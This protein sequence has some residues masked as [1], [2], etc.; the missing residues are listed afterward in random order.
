VLQSKAAECGSHLIFVDQPYEGKISLAG[1]HQKWN[2]AV[3]VSATEASAFHVGPDSIADGLRGCRLA[4]P[5]ST[6]HR[7][8][9]VDGAHNPHAA[10][11]LV[12]TWRQQFGNEKAP[13]IF[14][15]LD[16]KDYAEMLKRLDAIAE[17]FLFIP[18]ASP[19]STDPRIFPALTTIPSK[20]FSSLPEA[21]EAAGSGKILI[22]GSSSWPARRLPCLKSQKPTASLYSLLTSHR[23]SGLSSKLA[24]L[25]GFPETKH[26]GPC[27]PVSLA[28]TDVHTRP[29]T[30]F[31]PKTSGT[32][33]VAVLFGGTL[34]LSEQFGR[35][36]PCANH[37]AV[38]GLC[39]C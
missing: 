22:T 32:C 35:S 19:R 36:F 39:L 34:T 4:R 6:G 10:E 30:D 12:Q 16:D 27:A 5:V 1:T 29:T 8:I 18:V 21:L 15:A 24:L 26:P 37:P 33:A 23:F 20:T 2:A 11:T 25:R 28:Q 13:V 7:N 14:G 3:A 9:I 17:S 31:S 38:G